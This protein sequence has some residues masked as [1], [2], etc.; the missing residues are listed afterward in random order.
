M[1]LLND[2]R[3]RYNAI[4]KDVAIME[5]CNIIGDLA[6]EELIAYSKFFRKSVLGLTQKQFADIVGLAQS[7]ISTYEGGRRLEKAVSAYI[8]AGLG[9]FY[10]SLT[11]PERAF[12]LECESGDLSRGL[13]ARYP[14]IVPYNYKRWEV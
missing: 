13:H 6:T 4:D 1:S 12:V 8:E 2:A 3:Y 10:G 5:G 7:T 14:A 11:P 9:H